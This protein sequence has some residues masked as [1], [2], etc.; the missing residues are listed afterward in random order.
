VLRSQDGGTTVHSS[1][2]GEA[3]GRRLGDADVFLPLPLDAFTLGT[4]GALTF[5][6]LGAFPLGTAGA[7]TLGTLG[8]FVVTL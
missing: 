2:V 4:A 7:F 6:V 5:G 8:F 1:A 3:E